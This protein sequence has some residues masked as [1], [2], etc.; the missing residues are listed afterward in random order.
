MGGFGAVLR[1]IGVA[2]NARGGGCGCGNLT[3]AV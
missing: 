2:G 3:L 1:E